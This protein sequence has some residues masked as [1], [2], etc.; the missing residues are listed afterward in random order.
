L[1]FSWR[2]LSRRSLA[3]SALVEWTL[4]GIVVYKPRVAASN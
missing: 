1:E 4:V 3:G 2:E